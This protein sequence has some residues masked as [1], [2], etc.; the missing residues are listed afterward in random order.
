MKKRKKKIIGICVS[1][2]FLYFFLP[3]PRVTEQQE[4]AIQESAFR[5]LYDS[6]H[7]GHKEKLKTFYVKIGKGKL[8]DSFEDWG[9]GG[10]CLEMKDPSSQLLCA[11]NDFPIEVK[12]GS[13]VLNSDPYVITATHQKRGEHIVLFAAGPIIKSLGLSRCRTFYDG[14]SLCAAEFESLFV[15]TP[16]GWKHLYSFMLWV[17]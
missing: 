13:L 4:I 12:P 7:Y 10:S 3:L 16:F 6:E 14:G 17:S 1:I 15:W 5:F 9:K 8:F 2:T 11:L